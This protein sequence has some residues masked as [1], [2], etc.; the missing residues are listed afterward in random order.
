MSV[1]ND[2]VPGKLTE[3]GRESDLAM[4]FWNWLRQVIPA[5][6]RTRIK[7]HHVYFILAGFDLLAVGSGLYLSHHLS[8]AFSETVE[9]NLVWSERSAKIASLTQAATVT[10]APG[11][12]VFESKDAL[13][14]LARFETSLTVFAPQ[15]AALQEDFR[16]NLPA[17][18]AV[19]PLAALGRVQEAMQ[20]MA[21]RTRG[22]LDNYG[23][24]EF[25]VA[26]ASMAAMDRSYATLLGEVGH[27]G[28]VLR[29]L[30]AVFVRG[31]L[32]RSKD[33]RFFEYLLG[34]M[35]LLMVA[36]VTVYGHQVGRHLQRKYDEI[37]HAHKAARTA[38][39]VARDQAERLEIVNSEVTGLNRT[40]ADQMAKLREAQDEIVRKGKLSQLGQL[41]ATVAHEIRNPLGAL[42]NSLF[43][44]GEIGA[45]QPELKP[46]LAVADRSIGRCDKIITE[47][48]DFAR[49]RAL[50]F[51][52][53]GVDEWLGKTVAEQ[54]Q[55]MPAA[56]KIVE[57]YGLGDAKAAFD[58][59][60]MQRVIINLMSNA[61]EAM[62]G[63]GDAASK[64]AVADA[65]LTISSRRTERGIEISV[66]DN[67]P[68]IKPEHLARI[69]EPLFTTKNFGVGLGIPAVEKI[70]EQHGGRLDIAST[71]GEGA[72]MTAWFPVEQA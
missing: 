62:V 56:V 45:D 14:E 16:T 30:E 13:A 22:L 64:P 38:E 54:R 35:I 58:P 59:S 11:N 34:A 71:V 61:S 32:Q 4:R 26:A 9:T 60:S 15:L 10:N 17:D 49:T 66:T 1:V 31:Q 5:A 52:Q 72:T 50:K 21:G 47:L 39:E 40:L 53:V 28:T 27:L 25:E 20:L 55:R 65:A 23:R 8:S 41:T 12:D 7:I 18:H 70:L 57:S 68:G 44:I 63:K 48:L 43:I 51:N 19:E 33:L 69:R 3:A 2:P 46:H 29:E 24:G 37:A 42:R 6:H 36:G 67:G